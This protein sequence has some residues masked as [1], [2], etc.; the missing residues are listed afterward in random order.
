MI[1]LLTFACLILLVLLTIQIA[2]N[3]D[4]RAQRD[5]YKE[6]LQGKCL[7]N[8]PVIGTKRITEDDV[9][10]AKHPDMPSKD[11][12]L[13]PQAPRGNSGVVITHEPSKPL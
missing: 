2:V 1:G 3:S 13:H 4:L 5:R 9:I 12:L 7:E 11:E 10:T 8:I 6:Q